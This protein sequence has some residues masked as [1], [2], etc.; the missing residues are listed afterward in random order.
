MTRKTLM[1]GI[2]CFVCGI[3]LGYATSILIN[4]NDLKEKQRKRRKRNDDDDDDVRTFRIEFEKEIHRL[5]DKLDAIQQQLKANNKK[6]KHNSREDSSD[7]TDYQPEQFYDTIEIFK[8]EINEQDDDYSR[9][10]E[11]FEN[12]SVDVQ[13]ISDY[14]KQKLLKN[15]NDVETLWRLSKATHL[16]SK[17]TVHMNNEESRKKLLYESF[18]MADKALKLNDQNANCHK[19]YA[20]SIGCLKDFV[21][22]REKIQ[23]GIK[24]KEHLDIALS[25]KDDDPTLYHLAGR[26]CLELLLISWAERKLAGM[27]VGYSLPSITNQDALQYFLKAYQLKPRWKENVF[28]IVQTLIQTN[29]QEKAH[30][31][32]REALAIPFNKN[33]G[34][35]QIMHDKLLKLESSKFS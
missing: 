27:I 11:M 14:L 20:I 16:L 22:I 7:E 31:Y 24:F 10:D 6:I 26:F 23:N 13:Y 25:L 12:D 2:L 5:Y 32:L 21:S 35:E 33:S 17:T 8:D 34:D 18:E 29:E 28:Y 15:P 3:L 30:E 9:I 19:W 1:T 4:D